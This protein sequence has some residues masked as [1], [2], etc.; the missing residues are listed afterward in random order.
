MRA[1]VV[2]LALALVQMSIAASPAY[3]PNWALPL[4]KHQVVTA[5]F[6]SES[7]CKTALADVIENDYCN[8][9]G[10]C[11][12]GDVAFFNVSD[13]TL[14]ERC[15]VGLRPISLLVLSSFSGLSGNV[16]LTTAPSDECL[17]LEGVSVCVNANNTIAFFYSGTSW[18][19]D[20]HFSSYKCCF[21][22]PTRC[23][24]PPRR[25][26][27]HFQ[28]LERLRRAL[29]HDQLQHQV[30]LRQQQPAHPRCRR[31][32]GPVIRVLVWPACR[33]QGERPQLLLRL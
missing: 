17:Y 26:R 12:G 30:F 14:H 8:P 5:F 22:C 7:D 3:T 32:A 2:L 20:Q 19:V 28:L 10:S 21:K 13:C 6:T 15:A 9:L 31:R 29:H 33:H 4:S 25:F 27:C 11:V 24:T 23:M 1:S 18:L 16:Q